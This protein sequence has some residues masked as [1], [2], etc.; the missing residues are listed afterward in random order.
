MAQTYATG[1]NLVRITT[2]DREHQLW[3]AATPREEAI[4]AVL[5][6]VPEGWAAALLPNKLKPLDGQCRRTASRGPQYIVI[7]AR[8]APDI[9]TV[10]AI[11]IATS[12]TLSVMIGAYA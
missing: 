10:H 9:A 5:K 6:V 4:T 8:S 12:Q 7:M 3:A 11:E 2:D 1:I